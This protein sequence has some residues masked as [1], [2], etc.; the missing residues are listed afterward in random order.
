MRLALAPGDLLVLRWLRLDGQPLSQYLVVCVDTGRF[1]PEY[2]EE[3]AFWYIHS[4][5]QKLHQIPFSTIEHAVEAGDL[6]VINV[7]EADGVS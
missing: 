7:K 4:Q 6:E 2:R 1:P 3:R 5:M